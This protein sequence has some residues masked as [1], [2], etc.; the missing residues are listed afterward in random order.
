MSDFHSVISGMT[1]SD[2][3]DIFNRYENK[4]SIDPDADI[5]DILSMFD[6]SNSD[7]QVNSLTEVYKNLNK[8][9]IEIGDGLKGRRL[10]DDKDNIST[11]VRYNKLLERIH[12]A[13]YVTHNYLHFKN[14]FAPSY[15][16]N[17]D[18]SLFKYIPIIY[19]DMKPFQKL[20]FKMFYYFECHNYRKVD[21]WIYEQITTNEG[22]CSH[23]WKPKRPI[24]DVIHE[25]CALTSEISNWLLFTTTKDMDNQLRDYFTK[26]RD[27]RFPALEK[28]RHVF[29]FTNGIYF[30][31]QSEAKGLEHLHVPD[32]Y[33]DLFIKYDS[34]EYR[35]LDTSIVSCKFFDQEFTC[36]DE[37][38]FNN[39]DTPALN[40]IYEYQELD[41]EVV[42]INQMMLGR[43]LYNVSQLDN[44]QVIP[45]LIG[46][47]GTGK[48]T[49]N[50]VVRK[51]YQ[52]E[53]IGILANNYQ[54]LF[55]LSDIYDKFAF[56]APEIK[57][58]WGIDQAEFQEMVS[59]GK[60]NVN[61][62]HKQ[63]VVV[64]WKAPGLLA[65]NEN[66]GFVDNASSIQRRVVVTR[67][68]KRVENGDP[69][70][71]K[72]LGREI[73]RILRKCNL[74]YLHHVNLYRKSDIWKWLPQYFIDTQKMMASA[75]N[76]L[77][78]YLDSDI[79][80]L[81]EDNLMP[82]DEFFKRFNIFCTENNFKKPMINIDFYKSPFQK[83]KITVDT[84][85]S[86]RYPPVNG[87]LYKN[88]TF[89]YG[90]DFRCK[91]DDMD[92]ESD[93]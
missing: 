6:V 52:H 76:A 42:K 48:S 79:L 68:D 78:A 18:T 29:S 47:G 65:G 54:K 81:K 41:P 73:D 5:K 77:Y 83:F 37:D 69:F 50:N 4:W 91:N 38:D 66:P 58:D 22:Y 85:A 27:K 45:F 49:I 61:I 23:A 12:Y 8:V 87:I 24:I 2:L 17:N 46:Q 34:E 16:D 92:E 9:I 35:Y 53:N 28:N 84:K 39:I 88:T 90:V 57:K 71:D 82:M 56:I 25:Q 26:T 19:E 1:D 74:L 10:M 75:S 93:L 72:K 86:K 7:N 70:L 33:T 14:T 51:F 80:E 21:D 11:L 3:T 55:G 60:V 15:S 20:I 67:F 13:F 40:S 64:E 59:G 31:I 44:W 62:K 32:K 63:S 89:L 36:A 30:S 43:M